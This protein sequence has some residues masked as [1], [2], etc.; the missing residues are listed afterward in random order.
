MGIYGLDFFL[1]LQVLESFEIVQNLFVGFK[2]EDFILIKT[3]VF[4]SYFSRKDVNRIHALPCIPKKKS[5]L[6]NLFKQS[7]FYFL[8]SFFSL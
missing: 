4:L 8:F 3:S 1:N 5:I 6:L 7:K 2:F